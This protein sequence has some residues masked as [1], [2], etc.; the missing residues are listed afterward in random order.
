M[1]RLIL[2]GTWVLAML[3]AA[4]QVPE[5]GSKTR[6]PVKAISVVLFQPATPEAVKALAGRLE[7]LGVQVTASSETA[8]YALLVDKGRFVR[9]VF[10]ERQSIPEEVRLWLAGRAMYRSQCARCHGEDGR[11]EGYPGTKSMAGIGN[12]YSEDEIER[13]TGL[14]GFVDL[15]SLTVEQR[16]ALTIFTAGL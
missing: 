6:I 10:R 7:P 16:R 3:M 14:A 2:S 15:S 11:D 8:P 5:L 9:R 4:Q 13:R 12:R 1:K